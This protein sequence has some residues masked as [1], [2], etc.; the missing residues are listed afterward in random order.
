MLE[1]GFSH[2]A[3]AL[4]CRP[5]KPLPI[6]AERTE[7]GVRR[8]LLFSWRRGLTA[9]I[10]AQWHE[11]DM[12]PQLHEG[13]ILPTPAAPAGPSVSRKQWF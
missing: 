9:Q 10:N 3:K 4:D 1:I 13:K 2:P 11:A 7:A 12:K 5:N 6:Q 8:P